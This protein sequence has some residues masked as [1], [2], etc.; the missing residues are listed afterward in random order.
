[1]EYAGAVYH[2]TV[3]G[4]ERKAI[5]R[6]DADRL[7]FLETVEEAVARFGVA[8]DRVQCPVQP[9]ASPKR[10]PVPGPFQNAPG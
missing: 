4:N 9:A 7:R 10:A 8:A 6:D 3:R 5:Y 2:V 1:V